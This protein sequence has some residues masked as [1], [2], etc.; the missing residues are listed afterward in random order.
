MI[1]LFLHLNSPV[2]IPISVYKCS[3][4]LLV[5]GGRGVDLWTDVCHPPPPV[6]G[7]WNKA[8]FP[9]HQY[10]LFIGFWAVSRQIH[11]TLSVT[12]MNQWSCSVVPNSLRSHGLQP[13]RLLHPWNFP[14]KSTGVGCH[15][16]LQ[17]IF[18]T[19]GLNPGL[20]H[21][22]QMLYPLSYQGNP[23]MHR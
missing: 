13:T 23:I 10:G 12:I 21:C 18:P 11:H 5:M 20:L 1:V 7:I 2:P 17:G 6:A 9:F 15:F 8:K 14:G 3:H 16:L 22:R 4:S 19:Q